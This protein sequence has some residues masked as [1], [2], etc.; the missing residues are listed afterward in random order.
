[1]LPA[2]GILCCLWSGESGAAAQIS[3]IGLVIE[4]MVNTACFYADEKAALLARIKVRGVFVEC[5]L[6]FDLFMTCTR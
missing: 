6:R 4:P 2:S 3:F 5:H 1:M